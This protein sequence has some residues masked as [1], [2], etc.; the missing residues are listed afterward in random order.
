MKAF[1]PK[2]IPSMFF[3][4][5]QTHADRVAFM[6]KDNQSW[7][8]TTYDQAQAQVVAIAKTM[9]A[10]GV[11]HGDRIGIFANNHPK[12]ALIDLAAQALGAITVPIYA[13]LNA[14]QVQYIVENA[15][16]KLFFGDDQDTLTAII[17]PQKI[18]MH[19][20]GVKAPRD[21]ILMNSWLTQADEIK[22]KDFYL[23][24]GNCKPEDLASIVYTSGT[25]GLPKGVMLTQNN[26]TSN[27]MASL[28]VISIN[29]LDTSVSFLPLSHMFE[30]TA[31]Y[32]CLLASGGTI[33]FC[34]D[35]SQ[36]GSIIQEIQPTI[37][38]TV[39]RL[40]EKIYQKIWNT[41]A[42]KP[43]ALQSIF[44]K[45]M[46]KTQK[47]GLLYP[48]FDKLFF[49]KI[50]SHLGG[51]LKYIISGGAALP[52]DICAFF[53]QCGLMILQGYG[54]TETSP[55]TNVNL[56]GKQKLGTVGPALPGVEIRISQNQE[57][58]VKGPN[59]MK[60]YYNSPEETKKVMT[61]DGYFK[62]GDIGHLDQ[63]GYLAITDRIKDLIVTSGGKKI[64]PLP[65][66]SKLVSSKWI[67]Q[68]CV[69]GESQKTIGALIVPNFEVFDH[70]LK[71]KQ[72]A[73]QTQQ[74]LIQEKLQQEVDKVNATLSQFEKIKTFKILD[75]PFSMEKNELTPTLKLRRKQIF[76]NH[77]DRI[78]MLFK[79][80]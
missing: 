69:V 45:A 42:S 27:V 62:T 48:L 30:R 78:E 50:R 63:D 11:S 80:V 32:Y 6:I 5:A 28:Q 38:V 20:E 23:R 4:A 22:D 72:D 39:P 51:K 68:V 49:K 37:L 64:A 21:L 13:T 73:H 74:K 10:S 36:V 16:P 76:E 67:E 53:D 41:F 15:Q 40:L 26:I 65:I 25:T 7:Q 14:S 1:E 34:P 33:A 56:P 71:H 18:L 44:N 31:G 70:V 52:D 55:V 17:H 75:Q 79:K 77:A 61:D 3:H 57:I 29:H 47:S 43:K 59:V 66:E 2:T 8:E 12:W 46:F 9:M 35:I 19:H 54:L 58:E 60:G 24:I